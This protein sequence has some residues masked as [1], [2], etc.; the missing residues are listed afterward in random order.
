MKR[1]LSR[2]PRTVWAISNGLKGRNYPLSPV[3]DSLFNAARSV[4]AR[5][6]ILDRMDRL[7]M[8]YLMPVVLG[9]PDAFCIL[10]TLGPDRSA[11]LGIK[12]EA[13]RQAAPVDTSN[14]QNVRF[15]PCGPEYWRSKEVMDAVLRR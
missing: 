2:K 4:N 12:P 5:Y 13:E 8:V 15:Q 1:E 14:P 6:V 7:S 9:R 11:I 10:Y 3:P